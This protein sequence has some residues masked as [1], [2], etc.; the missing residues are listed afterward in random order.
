M[1][2]H[3]FPLTTAAL[4]LGV[5]LLGQAVRAGTIGLQYIIRGGRERRVYADR[6]VTEGIYAH[7]RNP[8]Y[9]GN[10]SIIFG[11]CLTANSWTVLAIAIPLFSLFYLAITTAEEEFLAR[12][13]GAE[14]ERY[15]ESVPRFLPRWR[16]LATTLAG[17]EFHWR[18]L[19]VKE[20]GTLV[21]WPLR[22]ML[23]FLYSLWRDG[24]TADLSETWPVLAAAAL[25]LA[26]FY[27]AVRT[28]KKSRRLVAD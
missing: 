24:Q 7:S 11:V 27:G 25:L 28:L 15:V 19:L 14:Y 13:F 10:L 12:Q 23:V 2:L 3:L 9:V 4:W 20:Y 17:S 6:L 16:G 22:W 5:G 18:R 21:G 26:L 1:S 8:M